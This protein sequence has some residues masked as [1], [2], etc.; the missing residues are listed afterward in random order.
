MS[1]R[2]PQPR[3]GWLRAVAAAMIATAA[4]A[5]A[6]LAAAAGQS[7]PSA[8][9]LAGAS[10]APGPAPAAGASGTRQPPRPA[11]ID[12]NTASADELQTVRGI[13]PSIAARII[14]ER[15]RGPFRDLADLEARVKGIGPASVRRFAESGLV[16]GGASGKIVGGARGARGPAA[17][18]GASSAATT[19]PAA[20]AAPEAPTGTTT[21]LGGGVIRE[22]RTPAGA[23]TR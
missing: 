6:S 9:P 5:F 11:G 21:P 22:Y 3:A 2:P 8:A 7:G 4:V 12:V 10:T 23:G 17:G 16:V 1:A 18:A 15:A 19:A 14:E 13:G 20:P